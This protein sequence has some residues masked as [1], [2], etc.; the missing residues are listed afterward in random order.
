LGN[1]TEFSY[2]GL[3]RLISSVDALNGISSQSFDAEGSTSSLTDPNQNK[4]RFEYDRNGRLIA[5]IVAT[6]HHVRY[7]YNARDLLTKVTNGRGQQRHLEYDAVGRLIRLTDVD[8]T[9]EY[10]YDANGN[11][12]TVKDHQGTITRT[13]DALN[14]VTSYIDARGNRLSYQYDAVGNLTRLTY[15]DG[16]QVFYEYDAVNQLVKVIDWTNRIT[17]YEYD[18]NG[19]LIQTIRPN[20]TQQTRSYDAK[21]QLLTQT[22]LDAQGQTLLRYQFS[23]DAVGNIVAET[24]EPNLATLLPAN[25]EMSYGLANRLATVDQQNITLDAD[26]NMVEGLLQ[27]ELTQFS[28]DSRNRLTQAGN[29]Q[30]QYDAEN[31]RIAVNDTQYVINSQPNLSQALVRTKGNGEV[32]YY[33]YGLGLIGE[34]SAGNYF[35]YHFDYR[36]S[37]IAITNITGQLVD[38]VQY[39][40]FGI[41]LSQPIFDTPFLFNGLYGVI[42]DGNRLNYMRARY[43]S[44][45]IRRFVNQDVLLGSIADG[46]S[47][48]RFAYVKGNPIIGI[49]PFGLKTTIIIVDYNSYL[50]GETGHALLHIDNPLGEPLLYDPNGNYGRYEGMRNSGALYGEY[51][52]LQ[53]YFNYAQSFP[54]KNKYGEAFIF[55]TTP[56]QEFAIALRI[57]GTGENGYSDAL[58]DPGGGYCATFVVKSITGI[59][60]FKDL[61][62]DDITTWYSGGR[63][64]PLKLQDVLSTL[65]DVRISHGYVGAADTSGL[66]I[67]DLINALQAFSE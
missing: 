24:V 26:G 31:Q 45:E 12:L 22:E 32:T 6:G 3:N 63:G 10:T 51:A 65:P 8:G 48:N 66:N 54:N 11:V 2:D 62:V 37:T 67:N 59:G 56:E 16:K 29:T 14:R 47:L 34:E 9:I 57:E 4:T 52:N 46:Q 13:Y 58:G 50:A 5:E 53:K 20:G 1:S 61:D 60:P 39:S 15:P 18:A 17:Q 27:G 30:Y 28:F 7:E 21:G 33:V 25:T 43:Y 41:I 38:I 36:G 44:A 49:D 19:R 64:H 42:T 23:Y 55:F 35:S 40:P